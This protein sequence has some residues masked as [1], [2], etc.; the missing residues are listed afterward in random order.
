MV[1]IATLAIGVDFRK[2]LGPALNSKVAYAAKHGYQYV[3]A[4][5]EFWDRKKPIPWSKVGFMSSLLNDLS[6]GE[7]IF[8]SDADVMITNPE[9][10]R[11]VNYIFQYHVT[12]Q[13]KLKYFLMLI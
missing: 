11:V 2:S 13:D 3:Q 5:E 10:H 12:I 9:L 7:L 1:L 8:L 6:D 4:G